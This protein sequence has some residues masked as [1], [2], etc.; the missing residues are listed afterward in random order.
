MGANQAAFAEVSR[1]RTH[2]ADG[3]LSFIAILVKTAR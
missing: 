2:G 1:S 3:K